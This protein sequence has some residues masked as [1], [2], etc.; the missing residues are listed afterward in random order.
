MT[1]TCTLLKPDWM[2]GYTRRYYQQTTTSVLEST[3][4]VRASPTPLHHAP[5]G[6]HNSEE[7]SQRNP[8]NFTTLT[9]G[10]TELNG[11]SPP[12][13]PLA[14]AMPRPQPLPSHQGGTRTIV[15]LH[16]N[17]QV[18]ANLITC[19]PSEQS[20]QTA[21]VELPVQHVCSW[22]RPTLQSMAS[23][24]AFAACPPRG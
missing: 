10:D 21:G 2:S 22:R 12:L 4:H 8:E 17:S 3:A 23:L 18:A 15:E 7:T 14:M 11:A 9:R 20:I 6:T 1:T 24:G 5:K 16:P 19:N 13:N